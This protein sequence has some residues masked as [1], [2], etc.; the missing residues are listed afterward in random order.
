MKMAITAKKRKYES[1]GEI[2]R[3]LTIEELRQFFAS[4]DDHKHKLMFQVI[5]ELGCRVGEFVRIQ[6][7]HLDVGRS[8]VY[9]PAAN[10][11]TKRARMSYLP[12]GLMDELLTMLKRQGVISKQDGRVIRADAYLFHRGKCWNTRYSE[13]R[14][15]QIFRG[16][17]AK[18]GLQRVY[19][20]DCR[21]RQLK[22][23]TVHSLRHSHIMHYV[24]DRGVPLPIVQ[25][26]VGHRSL[27]TTSVYLAPST[28]KMA[29]AYAK[30]CDISEGAT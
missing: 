3:Y 24:V 10:T 26:Q 20:C 30:A 17:A 1:F 11:K 5:Y 12:R 22:M 21:G 25:K 6:V 19:A 27:K 23:H 8:T 29:E 13:N 28:A 14:V 2:I 7:M 4:V 15:R 9:F 18:S 16:Y